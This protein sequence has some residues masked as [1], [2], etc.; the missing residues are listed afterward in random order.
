[1]SAKDILKSALMDYNGALIIV[2]HDRDFLDGLIDNIFHF[3]QKQVKHYPLQIH[4][5]LSKY[6]VETIDAIVQQYSISKNNDIDQSKISREF[7]KQNDREEKKK[8]K[9]IERL[10]ISIHNI[11]QEMFTIDAEMASE[12]FY[13]NHER[14]EELAKRR[15][16]L[17]V[18]LESLMNE[19]EQVQSA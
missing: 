7:K 1:M 10:E 5:F 3:A 9:H 19:W 11:E 18:E 8:I 4:E 12:G 16:S 13:T 15:D 6:S 2:S 17:Q 14:V